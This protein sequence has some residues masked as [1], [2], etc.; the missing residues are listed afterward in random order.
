M[1]VPTVTASLDATTYAPGDEMLLTIAYAD[2]DT[3]PLTVTIT[4]TDAQGNHSAP[5]TVPVVVDPLAVTVQD[6]SGRTWTRV[7]DT[8]AVAVFR[9]VA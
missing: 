2:A 6:D 9:A 1:A 5:V 4:V 3:Q 7:S 8:G